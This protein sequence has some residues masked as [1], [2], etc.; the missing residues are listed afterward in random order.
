MACSLFDEIRNI[1]LTVVVYSLSFAGMYIHSSGACFTLD[2]TT[3]VKFTIASFF[4][5]G[6]MGIISAKYI[7]K[8]K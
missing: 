4:H 6:F 8:V 2:I 1:C 7:H 3:P 5:N